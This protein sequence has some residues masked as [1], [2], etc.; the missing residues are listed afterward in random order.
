MFQREKIVT[1]E[2][3][4]RR[5]KEATGI[6]DVTEVI[7]KFLTQDETA[8]N[9]AQM[10]KDAQLRIEALNEEK[11]GGGGGLG[12]DLAQSQTKIKVEE[13]RYAAPS[14]QGGRRVVDEFDSKLGEATVK[15]EKN[16]KRYERASKI[17]VNVKAGIDN[18]CDRLDSIRVAT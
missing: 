11:V 17:I 18:L 2:E 6:E 9:L 7:A 13:M 5:I 10:T 4:F 12:V 1:Y 15:C 8:A 16:R 3:A 14:H